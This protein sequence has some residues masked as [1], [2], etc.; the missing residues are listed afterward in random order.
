[1]STV[2]RTSSVTGSQQDSLSLSSARNGKME[3][4]LFRFF[5]DKHFHY[6]LFPP[7]GWVE[8]GGV[9][10][11]LRPWLLLHVKRIYARVLA[12]QRRSS[13]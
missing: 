12:F 11:D 9:V 8:P 6:S 5:K 10:R 2:A 7:L 13:R 4:L 3:V 1:M